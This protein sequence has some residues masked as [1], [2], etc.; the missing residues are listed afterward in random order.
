MEIESLLH[1]ELYA[2]LYKSFFLLGLENLQGWRRL[3]L[4]VDVSGH[5]VAQPGCH[6]GADVCLYLQPELP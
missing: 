3:S 2:G 4:S 5:P 6:H 1:K